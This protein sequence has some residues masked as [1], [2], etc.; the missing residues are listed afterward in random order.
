VQDAG[1]EIRVERR[2]Q[3]AGVVDAG[4]VG[5]IERESAQASL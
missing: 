3:S 1:Y 4:V 5:V 2:G